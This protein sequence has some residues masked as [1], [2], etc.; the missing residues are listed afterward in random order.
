MSRPVP[1][2]EDVV[3]FDSGNSV[4]LEEPS[5]ACGGITCHMLCR[6]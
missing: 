4:S 3:A 2:L 6:T 5:C 1:H